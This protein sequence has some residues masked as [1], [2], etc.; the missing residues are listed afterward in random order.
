MFF[1]S[2]RLLP[3]FLIGLLVFFQY[4][5]WFGSEG[6]FDMLRLKKQLSHQ[7]Q[8]NEVLAKRNQALLQQ[9]QKLQNNKEVMEGRARHE[10]GMTKKDETFYQAVN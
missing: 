5:L 6:I 4:R 7:V 3:V 8:Q 9:V 2:T 10:L 1:Y